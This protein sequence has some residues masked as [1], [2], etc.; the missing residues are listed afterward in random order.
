RKNFVRAPTTFTTGCRPI[1]F[2]TTPPQPASKARKMFDSLS[3]GGAEE[4]RNGFSNL[5]PVNVTARVAM[6]PPELSSFASLGRTAGL[7]HPVHSRLF[8]PLRRHLLR[9]RPELDRAAA[10][11][12]PN[13]E[14]RLVPTAERKRLARHRHADVH[15]D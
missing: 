13:P 2:T 12:I 10:G 11:N 6:V 14:L 8:V 4:S 1:V 5:M 15:A 3:V 7:R 9:L